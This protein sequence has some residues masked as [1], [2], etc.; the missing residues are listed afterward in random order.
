MKIFKVGMEW[1]VVK[2]FNTMVVGET[3][4]DKN[5]HIVI[6]SGEVVG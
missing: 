2:Y 3:M 1:I 4:M 5:F 6:D